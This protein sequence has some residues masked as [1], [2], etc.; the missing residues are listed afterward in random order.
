MSDRAVL[1]VDV[2]VLAQHGQWYTRSGSESITDLRHSP[3]EG[4]GHGVDLNPVAGRENQNLVD[5]LATA[6][7]DRQRSGASR[8]QGDCLKHS[9]RRRTVRKS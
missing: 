8:V 1:I 7:G 3:V 4:C 5:V 9:D 2:Q 6:N